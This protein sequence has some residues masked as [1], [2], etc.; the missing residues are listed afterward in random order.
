[1]LLKIVNENRGSFPFLT[2]GDIANQQHTFEW[3]EKVGAYCYEPKNQT[4]S[5]NITATNWVSLHHPWRVSPVWDNAGMPVAPS[6]NAAIPSTVRIPP[7]VRPELY[8]AYPMEDLLALCADAGFTPEGDATNLHQ[9]RHQLH[10][11]YEGR[12]WAVEDMKRLRVQLAQPKAEP[13]PAAVSFAPAIS[14][15]P[16]KRGRGRPRKVLQPA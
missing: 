2:F 16:V 15:S 9:V 6:P 11:Y 3:N 7:Y 5:D 10:R 12:A 14:P 4:E 1:M 8:D 13:P